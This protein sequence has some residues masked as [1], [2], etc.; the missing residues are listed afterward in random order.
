MDLSLERLRDDDDDDDDEDDGD[1][2]E[3]NPRQSSP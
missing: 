2:L 3:L 1:N